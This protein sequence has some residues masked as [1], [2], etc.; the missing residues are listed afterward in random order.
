MHAQSA[1]VSAVFG[2]QFAWNDS[3]LGAPVPLNVFM[4]SSLSFMVLVYF[5]CL[6][7]SITVAFGKFLRRLRPTSSQRFRR[8]PYFFSSLLVGFSIGLAH[9]VVQSV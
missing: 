4:L 3:I 1:K 2:T 5:Y 8:A 6:F 9:V 7:T